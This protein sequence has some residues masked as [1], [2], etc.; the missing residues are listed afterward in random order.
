[1]MV[2]N[3][4]L[5]VS[6]AQQSCMLQSKLFMRRVLCDPWMITQVN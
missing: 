5:A 6:E 4:F 1:M 2:S 3:R